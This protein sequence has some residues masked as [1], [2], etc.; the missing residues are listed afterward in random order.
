[1]PQAHHAPTPPEA[2]AGL[3]LLSGCP[4]CGYRSRV[5]PLLPSEPGPSSSSGLCLLLAG[6]CLEPWAHGADLPQ[7]LCTGV[8]VQAG[9]PL[10]QSS[11]ERLEPSFTWEHS[12]QRSGKVEGQRVWET[13]PDSPAAWVRPQPTGPDPRHSLQLWVPTVTCDMT[14]MTQGTNAPSGQGQLGRT[15]WEAV[16]PPSCLPLS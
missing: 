5:S 10:W 9:R 4:A 13:A 8:P 2:P 1:M 12:T 7:G 15:G 16:R 11:P 14:T 3:G 6:S